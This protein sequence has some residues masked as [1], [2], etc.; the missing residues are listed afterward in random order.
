MIIRA[1]RKRRKPGFLD[2]GPQARASPL[3]R[4]VKSFS[5]DGSRVKAERL[6]IRYAA[7]ALSSRRHRL[8]YTSSPSWIRLLRLRPQLT[9]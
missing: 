1:T 3:P 4:P 5:S 8:H 7:R 6:F 9:S 2:L